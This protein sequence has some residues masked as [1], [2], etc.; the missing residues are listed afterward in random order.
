MQ[1]L[2]RAPDKG[3]VNA[4]AAHA[5]TVTLGITISDKIARGRAKRLSAIDHSL[6][7]ARR[8][9]NIRPKSDRP[10]NAGA[11]AEGGQGA[12]AEGTALSALG[13]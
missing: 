3:A 6:G 9:N 10:A 4:Q 1:H 8:T 11:V 13:W 2:P 5:Q 12:G 7:R